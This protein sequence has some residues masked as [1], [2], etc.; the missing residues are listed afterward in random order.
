MREEAAMAEDLS[1]PVEK[2][3]Q[4]EELADPESKAAS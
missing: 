4:D 2:P 1:E 3:S